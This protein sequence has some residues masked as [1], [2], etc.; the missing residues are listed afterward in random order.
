MSQNC[1][2]CLKQKATIQ[3]G[4]CKMEI[5]KSCTSFVEHDQFSFLSEI[6]EFLSHQVYCHGCFDSQVAPEIEKL[7]QTMALAKEIFVYEKTQGKETRFIRRIQ[8]PFQVS[9]CADHDEVILRLAFFAA[10]AKFNSI[11]DV[12]IKS[13]KIKNGKYQTTSWSG[14]AVPANVE[15][16]Q[17]MKDRAIWQ[18]PN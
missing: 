16:H 14:T 7:N 17:L 12:D 4:L 6:P 18:N 1:Q 5:C 15:K 3:C 13:K 8:K 11:I 10:Q 9:D 2:T